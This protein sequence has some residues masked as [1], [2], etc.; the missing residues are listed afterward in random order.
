MKLTSIALVLGLGMA[1]FFSVTAALQTEQS[2]QGNTAS[3]STTLQAL[4]EAQSK[5]NAQEWGLT[6]EE[7]QR[8]Q[9]LSKGRR[10][11]LS[12]GLDPITT[13]GIEARS[14]EERRH[15]AD[16]SVKQDFQR[17]EAELAFQREV[18]A[19]WV[20]VYP[21]ILPVRSAGDA[22]QGN[23]RLALFVR[24]DCGAPCESKVA[25]LLTSQRLLDIYLV[26]SEGKDEAVRAWA[27]KL[28]IPVERVKAKTLTLNHDRGQWI[29]FGQG[30]MPVVLQQGENGWQVTAY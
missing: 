1:P 24:A 11:I 20:R 6:T 22:G 12:P 18:N 21:G 17:V 29:K 15:Y 19:A 5:K 23:G 26:G 4:E 16:L 3:V 7:W 8:Y 2:Q 30:R 9:Q 27:K 10:G 25:S 13:L 28:A 14:E